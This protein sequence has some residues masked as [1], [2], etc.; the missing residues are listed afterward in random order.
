[1]LFHDRGKNFEVLVFSSS[2]QFPTKN[3]LKYFYSIFGIGPLH[4]A[5]FLV[6][7]FVERRL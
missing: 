7:A 3:I 2:C 4:I 6:G 5:L 1:M